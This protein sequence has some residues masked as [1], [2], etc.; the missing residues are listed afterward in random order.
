VSTRPI[1]PATLKKGD[2]LVDEADDMP[3]TVLAVDGD[4]MWAK[5]PS[6]L[7]FSWIIST[8]KQY[9]WRVKVPTVTVELHEDWR[10]RLECMLPLPAY[11]GRLVTVLDVLEAL[12]LDKE[13]S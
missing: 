11:S 7:R 12:G 8:A 10:E 4:D 13:A 9:G 6:G 3:Y 1:D 5:S 2:V